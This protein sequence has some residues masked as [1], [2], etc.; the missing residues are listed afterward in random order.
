MNQTSDSMPVF[1]ALRADSGADLAVLMF[2]EL[3][4]A[5][6]QGSVL[7]SQEYAEAI[8]LIAR[9]LSVLVDMIDDNT[10]LVVTADHGQVDQGG[11]GGVERHC[12][13]VPLL[14]Y[15]R[16]SNMSAVSG[17]EMGF[18][19]LGERLRF[20]RMADVAPT[21]AGLLGIPEPRESQGLFLAD[22]MV[23]SGIT[24]PAKILKIYR[25]K[26]AVYQDFLV[27]TM[28]AMERS[29]DSFVFNSGAT[30]VESLASQIT[31]LDT[32]FVNQR[33]EDEVRESMYAGLVG[34]SIWFVCTPLVFLLLKYTT[35]HQIGWSWHSFSISFLYV[36][37]YYWICI[38]FFFLIFAG[39]Y[40]VDS[41]F[42]WNSSQLG[43]SKKNGLIAMLVIM[44]FPFLL[45]L[46]AILNM[47]LTRFNLRDWYAERFRE[48]WRKFPAREHNKIFIWLQIKAY[49]VGWM[50]SG[51]LFILAIAAASNQSSVRGSF[52]IP[53]KSYYN[54]VWHHVSSFLLF[55]SIPL[56]IWTNTDLVVA[57]VIF[58]NTMAAAAA[59]ESA[60]QLELG[61]SKPST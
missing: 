14:I 8:D 45:F 37:L 30:D 35:L 23:Y 60:K 17:P 48:T 3:D 18:P 59:A 27:E 56:M 13:H 54:W 25:N 11:H 12:R 20:L 34:T 52:S 42:V 16:H 39:I 21:L 47:I 40:R 26:W 1:V 31:E 44:G 4:H 10:V 9:T 6:H 7:H 55:M 58:R 24:D 57:I 53:Y 5:S 46:T 33:N 51:F 29:V 19:R 49:S 61:G 2:D 50:I 28:D 15:H 43:T 32:Y 38:F 22:A 41:E 36:F